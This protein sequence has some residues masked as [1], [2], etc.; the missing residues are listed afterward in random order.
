MGPKKGLLGGVSFLLG[1]FKR[2]F[3][4]L[5][6]TLHIGGTKRQVELGT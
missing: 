5:I 6:Q 4:N 2:E 1:L 3:N